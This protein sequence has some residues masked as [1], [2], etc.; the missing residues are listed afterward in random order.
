MS[1]KKSHKSDSAKSSVAGF[2]FQFER[3]LSILTELTSISHSI[4]IE[5]VDD[6][7]VEKENGTILIADQ[8][9]HSI[10][11][12]G[13]T[14]QDTSYALWR[15]LELWVEKSQNGI[16]NKDTKFICS[17]NKS[18]PPN[19]LLYAIA[20]EDFESVLSKVKNLVKDQKEKLDGLAPDRGKH[21]K[22]I[23]RIIKYVL[24]EE[25]LFKVVQCNISID[26]TLNLKEEILSKLHL[27]S[28]H[29]KFNQKENVYHSLIG[30]LTDH[31]LYQWKNN[32]PAS[33][34]K[35]SFNDKYLSLIKSPSIVN[36]I[37]RSQ[38]EITISGKDLI[39]KDEELFVKQLTVLKRKESTK[40]RLINN[41]IEDY[42]RFELEQ[43]Y[44]MKEVGELTKKD[45]Q[46][47]IKTCF[48]KWQDCY[49][50]IVIDEI[51]NYTEEEQNQLAVQIYDH[52][53]LKMELDFN[54]EWKIT[55]QSRYIKNG[56]FLVLSN[57]PEIGWHPD[58]ENL[59]KSD[60][61]EKN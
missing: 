21:I 3:A 34:N 17:S 28:D 52:L 57:I 10:S 1:I 2:L 35:K 37:F 26:D 4:T 53:M 49:D 59:F 38:D 44:M 11:Q 18:I 14:F 25:E 50:S 33:F 20:H 19:S 46:K 27:D 29:L 15:T 39:G 22:K 45:F 48:M 23:L 56:S 30:W 32:A 42:I 51:G 8:A 31:S 6:I 41:A 9:K 16:F 36:V 60:K 7:A 47:F 13:S 12:S 55:T 43:V 61:K 24:K 54:E 5:E 40:K 58:W